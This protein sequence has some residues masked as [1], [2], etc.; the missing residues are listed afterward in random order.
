MI[1]VEQLCQA[2]RK[3]AKV[4]QKTDFRHCGNSSLSHWKPENIKKTTDGQCI[5][6]GAGSSCHTPWC[7]GNDLAWTAWP[8]VPPAVPQGCSLPLIH[9]GEQRRGKL[10]ALL[11]RS[12]CLAPLV[13]GLLLTAALKGNDE[14]QVPAVLWEVLQLLSAQRSI[15]LLC[16]MSS[17]RARG[18]VSEN[19]VL[20]FCLNVAEQCTIPY[21]Q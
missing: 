7:P 17:L 10:W 21:S 1:L 9:A 14:K 6:T 3:E 20:Y 2:R 19:L 4:L 8:T 18:P 15:H 12:N 16:E 5:I 13:H 11:R